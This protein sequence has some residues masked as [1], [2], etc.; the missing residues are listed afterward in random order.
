[1]KEMLDL[2]ASLVPWLTDQETFLFPFPLR[3]LHLG[4][5]QTG[6]RINLIHLQESRLQLSRHIEVCVFIYTHF[7][8]LLPS[9]LNPL[10]TLSRYLWNFRQAMKSEF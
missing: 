7:P 10:T 8:F 4:I 6:A 1:M 5:C 9:F 2:M 3:F